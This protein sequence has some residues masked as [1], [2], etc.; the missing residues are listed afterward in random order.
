[1]RRQQML[2]LSHL[3]YVCGHLALQIFFGICTDEGRQRPVIKRNQRQRQ[4]RGG[5]GLARRKWVKSHNDV[6]NCITLR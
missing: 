5:D 1:M 4:T 2:V 3:A 6:L